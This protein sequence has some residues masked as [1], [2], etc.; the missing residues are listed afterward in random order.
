MTID[1]ETGNVVQAEPEAATSP[2]AA[3]GKPVDERKHSKLDLDKIARPASVIHPALDWVNGQLVV[4]VVFEDGHRAALTSK[5]GLVEIDQIGRVC[6]RD[7]H[8]DSP[9]T[10]ELAKEFLAYLETNPTTC[11]KAELNALLIELTEYFRRFVVFPGKHWASVMATW[12]LGTYLFPMFQN[13]PYVWLTSREPGCGKSLLG[14]ILA[15]LSFN[16]EFMSSPTEANMFHLPE[17]NRG[18]Q[19]W[20]EVECTNRVERSKFQSVTAILLV[21]YRNGAVVPRQ[22][23][24]SWDKQVKYHVFCPR[25]LIGLS[26]LPET[27]RQRSIELRLSKRT[28]DEE[29]EIYRIHDHAEEEAHLRAKCVLTALKRAEGVNRSYRDTTLRKNIEVLL[30]KVG[31]EVDDIW[32]PL[33][34]VAGPGSAD[35]SSLADD[36]SE[37]AKEL[38]EYRE[39]ETAADSPYSPATHRG[40]ETV[41]QN[42]ALLVALT[43]LSCGP[44]EPADLADRVSKGLSREVSAQLLSKNLGRLGIVAKKQNGR[45]V[46]NVSALE[47]ETVKAKLGIEPSGVQDIESGQQ[48]RDGQQQSEEAEHVLVETT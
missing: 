13:Y 28:A 47:L 7:G 9:V 34:A 26:Q 4:G 21:G 25:V 29:A 3:R 20:D 5:D 46:F 22:V 35:S 30:G 8:F 1:I 33:F 12:V 42:K 48:G 16:G 41:G 43:V 37:A 39:T 6:E 14:Q 32:L 2:G 10:P 40:T 38:T 18:V 19:V 27:A 36:L 24:K 17:Q 15:N 11:P 45:R 31:R 44:T 23:G